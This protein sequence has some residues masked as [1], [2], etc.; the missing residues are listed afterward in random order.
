M[1]ELLYRVDVLDALVEIACDSLD[2]RMLGCS[3]VPEV[4][5]QI[6]VNQLHEQNSNGVVVMGKCD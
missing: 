4:L 1:L 6:W 2:V 5:D 3:V